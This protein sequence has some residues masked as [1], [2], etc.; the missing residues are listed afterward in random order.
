MGTKEAIFHKYQA[1]G[2][3]YLVIPSG[4]DWFKPEKKAIE[5][6]CSREFGAGSDGILL[7]TEASE[8]L[9]LRIFNPDGSEAEKSG[10]GLRIF[11]SYLFDSGLWDGSVK[12]LKTM[13][14]EVEISRPSP[15]QISVNMGSAS[16]EPEDIP[17]NDNSPWIEKEVQVGGRDLKLTCLSV[18]NPHCVILFDELPNEMEIAQLGPQIEYYP[19]FSKRINVQFVKINSSEQVEI[20]IWERGA[21]HTLSSGSSSCAVVYALNYLGKVNENCEVK[22]KG[23]ELQI[24]IKKGQIFMSGPVQ[25]SY[26][27]VFS[28]DFLRSIVQKY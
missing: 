22:M 23:G 3:D 28:E 6:I 18:G 8:G 17:L 9:D 13:G 26:S 10:N 4:S 16:F 11:S 27:G 1:C 21:G 25:K 7:Q 2:N 20:R 12:N 24:S 19:L 15:G 14:G 5:I